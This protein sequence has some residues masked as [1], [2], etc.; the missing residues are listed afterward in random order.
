[1]RL[2]KER[3]PICTNSQINLSLE[4]MVDSMKVIPSHLSVMEKTQAYL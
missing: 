3:K 2:I 1:M 4:V